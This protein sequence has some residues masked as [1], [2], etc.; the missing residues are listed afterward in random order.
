[1]PD[2]SSQVLV[3]SD[4]QVDVPHIPRSRE[5]TEVVVRDETHLLGNN[6]PG[7]AQGDGL[8]AQEQGRKCG[9]NW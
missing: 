2:D 3:V 4:S 1:M 7:E 6:D 9:Q 8:P 5:D